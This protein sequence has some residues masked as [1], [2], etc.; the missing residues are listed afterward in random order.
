MGDT[1]EREMTRHEFDARFAATAS[2]CTYDGQELADLND[3]VFDEV[4]HLD[5]G[6]RNTKSF[7]Q[8]TFEKLA[9]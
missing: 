5:A 2:N 1:E 8:H 6:D 7:V 3:A 4:A 9:P